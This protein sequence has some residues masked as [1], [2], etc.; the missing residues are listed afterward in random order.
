MQPRTGYANSG[1]LGW[2]YDSHFHNFPH[3]HPRA[4]INTAARARPPLGRTP[5]PRD[6]PAVPARA[7]AERAR[8]KQSKNMADSLEHEWFSMSSKPDRVAAEVQAY[9]TALIDGR[10]L[11]VQKQPRRRRLPS[12]NMALWYDLPAELLAKIA[13]VAHATLKGQWHAI[14]LQR[15]SECLRCVARGV[16]ILVAATFL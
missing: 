3:N 8:N 16:T 4:H 9:V 10:E 7:R 15:R 11:V 12:A 14:K 13:T 6:G 2:V 5:P 1:P